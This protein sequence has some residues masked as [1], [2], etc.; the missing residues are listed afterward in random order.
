M[1]GWVSSQIF[2]SLLKLARLLETAPPSNNL[3]EGQVICWHLELADIPDLSY[4]FMF[5]VVSRQDLMRIVKG[6][7]AV[8]CLFSYQ[9]Q[10]K[11]A[12]GRHLSLEPSCVQ[13]FQRGVTPI[14][15]HFEAGSFSESPSVWQRHPTQLGTL[16]MFLIFCVTLH[17]EKHVLHV[18]ILLLAKDGHELSHSFRLLSAGWNCLRRRC[19]WVCVKIKGTPKPLGLPLKMIIIGTYWD[20]PILKHTQ[21]LFQQAEAKAQLGPGL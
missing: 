6:R 15:V 12:F 21:F 7:I 11:A 13:E 8:K 14:V 17:V 1:V 16:D 3:Q 20:T 2:S 9:G 10:Q 19:S 18:S 4:L 5:L